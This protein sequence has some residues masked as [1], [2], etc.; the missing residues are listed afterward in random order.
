MLLA[1][2][3]PHSAFTDLVLHEGLHLCAFREAAGHV[4]EGPGEDG[5]VRVLASEDAERWHSR[6]VLEAPGV[7]LRDPKLVARP[8][9]G[10]LVLMGG[11]RYE[12]GEFQGRAPLV[13]LSRGSGAALRFDAPRAVTIDPAI[14]GE[15]DW[16]WDAERHGDHLHGTVY[17]PG[18]DARWALQLVRSSD[19]LAWEHVT[20][21]ELDGRPSEAA[22]AFAPGGRLT[23][24][25]R[26]D[27]GDRLGRVGVSDPPHTDWTWRPL[28][29]RL[30]GPAI[31][32]LADGTLVL[33]TR[34]HG[35][36][37]TR[38]VLGVVR[39]DGSFE[40]RVTLP[41]GGDTGYSGLVQAGDELLVS[42]YSSHTGK[43]AM[44]LARV[45]L[46]ELR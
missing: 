5:V 36:D 16:L 28:D 31:L 38:T 14:R 1:D 45:P 13:A 18:P 29:V 17:Q 40:R 8:S 12:G 7:D 22:L 6:A 4:P 46:A 24:V 21:L 30:G 33:G 39:L 27:G 37:D 2:Q 44:H 26:R 10:L 15:R 9:G 42:Y 11:S 3:A 25:V 32:R 19:G 43:T 20:R 41:S 23:A 34:E 35:T